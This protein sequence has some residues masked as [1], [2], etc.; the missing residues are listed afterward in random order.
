MAHSGA[1]FFSA[2]FEVQIVLNE[3]TMGYLLDGGLGS[4]LPTIDPF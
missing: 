3:L 1:I 2:C 4:E